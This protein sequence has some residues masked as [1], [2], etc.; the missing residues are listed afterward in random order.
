[1]MDA[2]HKLPDTWQ[3]SLI[4]PLSQYQNILQLD[5]IFL[6]PEMNLGLPISIFLLFFPFFLLGQK[7]LITRSINWSDMPS[8]LGLVWKHFD[9][10]QLFCSSLLR[11]RI[12]YN[13][14]SLVVKAWRHITTHCGWG[15]IHYLLLG[16]SSNKKVPLESAFH[17]FFGVH[18]TSN[19]DYICSETDFTKV[20]FIQLLEITFFPY[21]C[22]FGTDWCDT[23]T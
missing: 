11:P 23:D 17:D 12:S 19:Y 18:L 15:I 20:I 21:W 22:C 14:N 7:F 6:P 1:M 13:C 16:N 10:I 2:Y 3:I 5:I 4:F 9:L 8:A